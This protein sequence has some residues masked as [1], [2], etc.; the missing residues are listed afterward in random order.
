MKML[1]K[2]RLRRNRCTTQRGSMLLELMIAIVVLAT[3]MCGVLP[4]LVSAMYSNNRSGNDTTSTMVAEHVIEQIAAEQASDNTALSITDCTGTS[5]SISTTGA[6]SGAGTGGAH[7]GNG[8]RLTSAGEIDW[9]QGYSGTPAGYK[10][11]YTACGTGGKQ[12][13]YDVRWDVISLNSTNNSARMI[14]VSAR[15][16]RS[17]TVGGLRFVTPA[18]LRTIGGMP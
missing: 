9:T 12:T 5:Y 14:F 17:T 13:I 3:G 15:P 6:A 11:R 10:M 16:S 7:G 18:Q 8:A 4:L 1:F 2:S